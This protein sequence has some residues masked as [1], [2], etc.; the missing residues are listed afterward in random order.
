[1]AEEYNPMYNDP[2]GNY[3]QMNSVGPHH[4]TEIALLYNVTL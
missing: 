4:G 1:M 3:L 2:V